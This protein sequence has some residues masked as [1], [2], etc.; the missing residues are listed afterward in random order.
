MNYHQSKIPKTIIVYWKKSKFATFFKYP[1]N[2]WNFHNN[3]NYSFFSLITDWKDDNFVLFHI[4]QSAGS[5]LINREDLYTFSVTFVIFRHMWDIGHSSE[6]WEVSK[7]RYRRIHGPKKHDIF[8]IGNNTGQKS[9]FETKL[10]LIVE[11]WTTMSPKFDLFVG[12][13]PFW[14]PAKPF[15]LSQVRNSAKKPETALHIRQVD[16]LR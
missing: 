6:T 13:H 12:S 10:S 9:K 5:S 4:S 2:F 16:I 14:R 1:S 7:L 8:T 11:Q 3:C 15:A